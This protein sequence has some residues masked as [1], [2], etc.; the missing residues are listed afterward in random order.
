MIFLQT[1]LS[2]IGASAFISLAAVWLLKKWISARLIKSIQHEYDIK[3][4]EF[5]AEWQKIID[6]NRI[7]FNWWHVEQAKAIKETYVALAELCA[8]VSSRI[9]CVERN[10]QNCSCHKEIIEKHKHTQNIWECNKIFID[11]RLHSQIDEILLITLDIKA[12]ASQAKH[13]CGPKRLESL[14]YC[15]ENK[16]KIDSI[17]SELRKELRTIMSGGKANG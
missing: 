17:L 14:E 13:G 12:N 11:E 5:K 2:S 1:I 9:N 16:E 6:E 4:G 15:R 8:A 7:T 10:V 3:L